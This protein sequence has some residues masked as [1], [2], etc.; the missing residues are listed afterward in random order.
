[1]GN[2]WLELA[3][4]MAYKGSCWSYLNVAAINSTETGE[5]FSIADAK[6]V[7]VFS[8]PT[9]NNACSKKPLTPKICCNKIYNPH[10]RV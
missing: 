9:K 2:L 7:L 10:I 5:Q 1:M 4:N 3:N 6:K 8:R